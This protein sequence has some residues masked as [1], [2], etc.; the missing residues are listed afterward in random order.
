[1][2]P[3]NFNIPK[4]HLIH[5]QFNDDCMA[6]HAVKKCEKS[7]FSNPSHKQ[8]QIHELFQRVIR[9]VM[10]S[11]AII[12][13]RQRFDSTAF[14]RGLT[15]EQAIILKSVLNKKFNF[16]IELNISS[17]VYFCSK[18]SDKMSQD[19]FNLTEDCFKSNAFRRELG[20]RDLPEKEELFSVKVD[21]LSVKEV[22]KLSKMTCLEDSSEE[23][24][25]FFLLF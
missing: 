13:K 22:E 1:M 18:K 25:M 4:Y 16:N 21:Y 19:Q 23:E 9:E 12:W 14:T 24:E 2:E 5:V 3:A 6:C 15:I 7:H 11:G 20:I 17:D 10:V 8:I